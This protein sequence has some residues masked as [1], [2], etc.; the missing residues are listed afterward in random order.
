MVASFL[1]R[2]LENLGKAQVLDKLEKDVRRWME[3]GVGIVEARALQR[4][5]HRRASSKRKVSGPSVG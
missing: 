4:I 2:V 1:A 3:V 5:V